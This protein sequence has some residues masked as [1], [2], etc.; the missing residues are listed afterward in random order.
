MTPHLYLRDWAEPRSE[1]APTSSMDIGLSIHI[2]IYEVF[3]TGDRR[4]RG[5][6][7]GVLNESSKL[8]GLEYFKIQL[9][10]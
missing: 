5:G 2:A 7:L 8:G 10:F 4:Y 1:I 6:K 9:N 3:I